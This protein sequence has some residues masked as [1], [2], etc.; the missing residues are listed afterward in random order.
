MKDIYL[1]D[2]LML[3]K[4]L[5][6]ILKHITLFDFRRHVGYDNEL[7]CRLSLF[8]AIVF[9]LVSMLKSWRMAG[10]STGGRPASS[11][12]SGNLSGAAVANTICM[13]TE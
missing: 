4:V 12:A 1:A 13:W 6:Y 2:R 3:P 10:L 7:P 9:N 5:E 11:T 8:G